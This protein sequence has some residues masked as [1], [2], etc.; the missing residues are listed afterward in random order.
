MKTSNHLDLL[1]FNMGDAKFGLDIKRIKEIIKM[2]E[3]TQLPDGPDFMEGVINVSGKI[4][5]VVDLRKMFGLEYGE[6]NIASLYIIVVQV[7]KVIM[8]M[9]VNKVNEILQIDSRCIETPSDGIPLIQFLS[10]VAKLEEG[11]MLV[12]DLNKIFSF[13]QKAFFE[14]VNREKMEIQTKE[15]IEPLPAIK[16]I[17]HQRAVSLSRIAELGEETKEKAQLLSFSLGK[18]WYGLKAVY[19]KEILQPSRITRVPFVP[20]CIMG[21]INLRGEIVS[22]V[23]IK[24]ILDLSREEDSVKKPHIIVVEAYKKTVGFWVDGVG[25]IV[26]FLPSAIAPPLST[27]EKSKADFIEGEIELEKK[28]RWVTLLNLEKVLNYKME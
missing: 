17:L 25:E 12:L 6:Q 27:L 21:I 23:D 9:I 8:G 4:V 26:N 24:K 20:G 13:Q 15:K 22:I 3:I 16:S 10:G 7:E 28:S 5:P 18:E 11:L 14:N 1:S 2:V 19:I